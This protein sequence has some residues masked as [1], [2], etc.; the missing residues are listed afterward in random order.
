MDSLPLNGLQEN[1]LLVLQ[2]NDGQTCWIWRNVVLVVN[3]KG[4]VLMQTIVFL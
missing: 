2:G 1:A 3:V 4:Y